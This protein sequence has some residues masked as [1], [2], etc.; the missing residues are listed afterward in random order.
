MTMEKFLDDFDRCNFN[1]VSFLERAT[2]TSMIRGYILL[3]YRESSNE[4]GN[5]KNFFSVTGFVVILKIKFVL[6]FQKVQKVLTFRQLIL[7]IQVQEYDEEIYEY[8]T[9]SFKGLL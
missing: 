5:I 3:E 9:A 1:S 4:R 7:M 6:G 8:C 2:P